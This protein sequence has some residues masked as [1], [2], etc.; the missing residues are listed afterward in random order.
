MA[1]AGRVLPDVASAEGY[2]GHRCDGSEKWIKSQWQE[3]GLRKPRAD[4]I[5]E[6]GSRDFL[7]SPFC[8]RFSAASSMA[9][10]QQELCGVLE[11]ELSPSRLLR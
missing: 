10:Q 1:V 7:H 3:R 4:I 11:A 9:W 6:F 5:K 2:R 8:V